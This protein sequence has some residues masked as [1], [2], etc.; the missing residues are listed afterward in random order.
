[1]VDPGKAVKYDW[2]L[3]GRLRSAGEVGRESTFARE[4]RRDMAPGRREAPATMAAGQR[5]GRVELGG[6]VNAD[7]NHVGGGSGHGGAIWEGAI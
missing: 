1:M 7:A 2:D 4:S 3:A 5:R 6:L